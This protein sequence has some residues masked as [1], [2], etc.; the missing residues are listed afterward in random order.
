MQWVWLGLGHVFVAIGVA[1]VFLPVLPTV[2]FL[3]LAAACYSRGSKRFERWLL[4]HPRLGP[5]VRDWRSRGAIRFRAKVAGVTTIVASAVLIALLPGIS[6][7]VRVTV[8]LILTT[9][10]VYILS[11]PGR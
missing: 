11:R 9:A 3:L 10:S 5:A 1:G 2:P 6:P 8:L 7:V 4:N